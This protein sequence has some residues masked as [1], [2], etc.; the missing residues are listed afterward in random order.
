LPTLSASECC[1][2]VFTVTKLRNFVLD[3]CAVKTVEK[4]NVS[5]NSTVSNGNVDGAEIETPI[6]ME[7]DS[8]DDL[9]EIVEV[10]EEKTASSLLNHCYDLLSSLSERITDEIPHL[11]ASQ[12]RKILQAYHI[13][14]YQADEMVNALE[15]EIKQRISIIDSESISYFD[16]KKS[17]IISKIRE[18]G[19][20]FVDA[21]TILTRMIEGKKKGHDAILLDD[22]SVSNMMDHMNRAIA[23]ACEAATRLERIERGAHIDVESSLR[24][25]EN[26]VAFEL[27]RCLELIDGYRLIE[28]SSGTRRG[29]FT[30]GKKKN[31]GKRILSRLFQ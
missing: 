4:D 11:T 1:R 28:F 22:D 5:T 26:G 2:A 7:E 18:A 10:N 25:V 20:Q 27:G 16:G 6:Y 17:N 30:G 12:M 31:L 21:S 9:E 24:L 23:T 19:D 13:M 14:P 15:V 8:D 29:R 3:I